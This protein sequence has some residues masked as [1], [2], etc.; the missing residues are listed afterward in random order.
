MRRSQRLAEARDDVAQTPALGFELVKP[1]LQLERHLVER[2]AEQRELVT[3]LD[4]HTFLQI[5]A[6]DGT[7]RVDKAADRAHD[8][9]TFDVGDARDK[10]ER[11]DEA[12]QQPIRRGFVRGVDDGLR[13]DHT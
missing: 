3:S 11:R 5:A 1:R 13:G 4:R 7:R 9:T 12:D 6:R 2:P 8:R 10:D